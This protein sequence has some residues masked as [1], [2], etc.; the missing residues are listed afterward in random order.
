M[1]HRMNR[2]R[3]SGRS[4]GFW[5][6]ESLRRRRINKARKLWVVM[7]A[8]CLVLTPATARADAVTVVALIQSAANY[9][10]TLSA[11]TW[12][13]LA[14]TVYPAVGRAGCRR[15]SQRQDAGSVL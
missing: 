14:T 3:M 9:L 5:K 12:L 8:I 2:L 10:G 6:R 15:S 11:A 7:A 1:K 13:A 4:R